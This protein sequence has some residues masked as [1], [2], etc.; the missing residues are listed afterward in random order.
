MALVPLIA[1]KNQVNN[2]NITKSIDTSPTALLFTSKSIKS[3]LLFFT[4]VTLVLCDY[5]Y[6]YIRNWHILINMKVPLSK[7][8]FL[9]NEQ[10]KII[11][12]AYYNNFLIDYKNQDIYNSEKS[13]NR[14]MM[15]LCRSRVFIPVVNDKFYPMFRLIK[16][17]VELVEYNVIPLEV[18][19]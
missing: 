1:G 19:E 10:Q 7:C 6:I 2:R 4:G 12:L 17:G 9:S 3:L 13:F 5:A 18:I 16:N 14:S 11:Y 15:Q 8:R